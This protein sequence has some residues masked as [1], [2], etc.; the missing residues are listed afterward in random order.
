MLRRWIARALTVGGA[1]LVAWCMVERARADAYQRQYVTALANLQTGET[2]RRVAAPAVGE[3]IGMLEI[4]TRGLSAAVVHGDT[5][6]VLRVAIGHLP[7]TP[8]PWEG[9]N[10][11]LAG[12]R[13][14]FFRSLRQVRP[15]DALW[16]K[17]AHGE[18]QYRV[19]QTLVVEPED[20]WVLD[21]TPVATLTLITCY[22]FN[23]VG[24]APQR[25]IVRA[26][27]IDRSAASADSTHLGGGRWSHPRHFR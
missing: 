12:H 16:L 24:N 22:P 6:E 7:D 10:T 2:A 19:R 20:V 9:G 23:Y 17:T 25:F 15:D 3:A 27:R 1:L 11:A 8:L 4:P 18:F 5:D 26:E 21:P 14:T 13:D